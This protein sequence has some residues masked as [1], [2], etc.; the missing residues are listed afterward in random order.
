[1]NQP[2]AAVVNKKKLLFLLIRPMTRK[3]VREFI[4]EALYAKKGG[5]FNKKNLIIRKPPID[6]AM[7]NGQPEYMQ[8]LHSLYTKNTISWGTMS[9]I[10]QPF[11]AHSIL[12]YILKRRE[13]ENLQIFEIGGGNV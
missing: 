5:Y 4:H 3:L 7:L 6:F 8:T 11:Y 10:F 13:D 9:D 2:V 12:N 1:V